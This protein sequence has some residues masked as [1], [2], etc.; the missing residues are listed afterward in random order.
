MTPLAVARPGRLA[1]RPSD[2]A[3]APTT[4]LIVCGSADRAD[5]GAALAALAALDRATLAGVRVHAVG[6]VRVE[7]LV[8]AAA[9]GPVVIADAAVGIGAGV[10]AVIPFERLGAFVRSIHVRSTHELPIADAVA[11]AEMLI[12]RTI[13]GAIVVIGAGDVRHG[14][15][16]SAPVRAAL[17]R[18]ARTIARV[19]LTVAER[20][21]PRGPGRW[22][23]R[24]WSE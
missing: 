17:P 2:P 15:Q 1:V 21:G 20:P 5:D 9:L 16:L 3:A 18:F 6:E 23:E 19:A 22:A 24:P 10:V 7:E 13:E 12:G 8:D 11:L 4:T 14:G